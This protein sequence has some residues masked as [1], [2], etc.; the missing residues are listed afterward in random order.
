MGMKYTKETRERF[1]NEVNNRSEG[2]TV[3]EACKH[4]GITPA[5]YYV[6]KRELSG[7][8]ATKSFQKG[9]IKA[10]TVKAPVKA[11][12]LDDTAEELSVRERMVADMMVH[13]DKVT[14]IHNILKFMD[15]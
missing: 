2:I 15:I 6:W 12:E 14:Q 13:L 1:V 10:V 8:K 3:A 5:N 7:K 9:K 4:G 11:M